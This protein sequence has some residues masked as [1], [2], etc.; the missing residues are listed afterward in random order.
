MYEMT[1]STI[2]KKAE[3]QYKCEFDIPSGFMSA[4]AK[5]LLTSTIEIFNRKFL[6]IGRQDLNKIF[7]NLELDAQLK[8]FTILMGLN[9]NRR[10][11][12]QKGRKTISA[13][14]AINII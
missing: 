9:A 1:K 3:S 12:A 13:I 11:H 8:L 2:P 5:L 7:E 10:T 4:A 6:S 14:K